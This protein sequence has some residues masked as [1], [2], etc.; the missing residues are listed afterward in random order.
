MGRPKKKESEK[1]VNVG[2][3][4]PPE[5]VNELEQIVQDEDRERGYL[6]RAL[7]IRGLA[8]YKKDG[9]L[10]EPVDVV[11]SYVAQIAREARKIVA[12]ASKIAETSE[13][14]ANKSSN[15]AA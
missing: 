8:A 13:R 12:A 2:L 6:T 14:S 5:H 15:K 4:L 1:K 9:L 11:D 3:Y 7:Y 10:V